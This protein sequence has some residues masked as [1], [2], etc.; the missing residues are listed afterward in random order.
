MAR[1]AKDGVKLNLWVKKQTKKKLKTLSD[2]NE[3]SISVQ[4]ENMT[5]D[6][7]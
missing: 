6:A 5:E 1:K 2:R 4:V 3:V 7:K